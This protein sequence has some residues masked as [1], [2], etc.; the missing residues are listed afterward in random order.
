MALR[1]AEVAV[2]RQPE[3]RRGSP[4]RRERD[5]EDRVR[6]E[7]ALVGGPVEVDQGPIDLPLVVRLRPLELGPDG[8]LHGGDREEDAATAEAGGVA[9]T[10]LERLVRSGGRAG[11]YRRTADGA[12]GEQHLDLDRGVAT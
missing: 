8:L 3:R 4:S 1:T 9:V 11:R 5:A 2:Q 6:A 12:V 7:G 10:A